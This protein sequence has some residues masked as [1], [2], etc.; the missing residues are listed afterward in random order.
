MHRK[1]AAMMKGGMG[2]GGATVGSITVFLLS[3]LCLPP[4]RRLGCF[5]TGERGA[6]FQQHLAWSLA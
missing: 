3:Y 2:G 6:K 1:V 5:V 4:L